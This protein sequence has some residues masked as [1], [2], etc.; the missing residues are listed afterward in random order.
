MKDTPS[1]SEVSGAEP[2][3]FFSVVLMMVDARACNH[4][5]WVARMGAGQFTSLFVTASLPSTALDDHYAP[6]QPLRC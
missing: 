4:A 5:M 6:F 1:P 2:A 3:P